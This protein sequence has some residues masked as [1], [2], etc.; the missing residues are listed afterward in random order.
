M[1]S[2]AKLAELSAGN[3]GF[4]GGAAVDTMPE[5]GLTECAD[6]LSMYLY[7]SAIA[8]YEYEEAVCDKLFE[9]A[10]AA[11]DAKDASLLE[12]AVQSMNE[13]DEEAPADDGGEAPAEE[14]PA[15]GGKNK[16]SAWQTIQNFF[17]KIWEFVKNI[18]A[19]VKVSI[20]Q[21][22]KD[23]PAFWAKYKDQF[24]KSD[25]TVDYKGDWYEFGVEDA[26]VLDLEDVLKTLNAKPLTDVTAESAK[27]DLEAIKS[28]DKEAVVKVIKDKLKIGADDD[29][30]KYVYGKKIENK[31]VSK[32][33][34][35][36]VKTHLLNVDLKSAK[37]AY[38]IIVTSSKRNLDVAK[39]SMGKD[40]DAGDLQAYAK[41]YTTVYNMVTGEMN[42]FYRAG[43][44][45]VRAAIAQAKKTV[46]LVCMGKDSSE[47]P[48]ENK[49]EEK[50]AEANESID[51]DFEF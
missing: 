45:G 23:G 20:D 27:A 18:A 39:A 13:A 11:I 3:V 30:V 17:K 19:K 10:M 12:A 29:Y 1:V 47:K 49:P 24:T 35:D 6:A 14:K 22:S 4:S 32:A 41:A 31:K 38:D 51:F 2:F 21:F 8:D 7:E 36:F 43:I 28:I 25:R 15:E 44:K 5:M 46:A 9:A 33:D 16:T 40:N 42:K 34:A 48:A 50:P 37:Q 26:P